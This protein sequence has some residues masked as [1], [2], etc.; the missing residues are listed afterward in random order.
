[1]V[2]HGLVGGPLFLIIAALA[3]RARGS[4]SLS[5]MG[6][7]GFRAPVF[8]ALFLVV[9]L[10]TLAMPGSSNFMGE[11]LILFGTFS[12]KLVFGLV[13]GAGVALA[14]VYLIRFYPRA[15]HHRPAPGVGPRDLTRRG[16]R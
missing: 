13:A 6:G 8:A 12:T 1:M 16:G 7:I 3:A 15:M 11:L 2:S 10:A 14:A 9:A 4:E 5:R